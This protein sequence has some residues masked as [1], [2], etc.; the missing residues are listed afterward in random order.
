[1]AECL[2]FTRPMVRRSAGLNT[3]QAWRQLLKERQDIAPLQLP[4]DDHLPSSINAM[5]LKN[6]LGDV[7]T[8][9]LIACMIGSSESWGLNSAHIHG[10]HVPVEEPSTASIADVQQRGRHVRFGPIADIA[11]I[12]TCVTSHGSSAIL[13]FN[14][15]TSSGIQFSSK[16]GLLGPL[17]VP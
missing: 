14:F 13:H 10:T 1:M 2:E 3:N 6:R 15:T 11:I 7:E 4:A 16:K 8:D 12:R 9:N 5:Y 17:C